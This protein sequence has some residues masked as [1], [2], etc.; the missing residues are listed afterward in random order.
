MGLGENI[1]GKVKE[2]LPV[3][4]LALQDQVKMYKLKN[5]ATKGGKKCG[6][7]MSVEKAS[8]SL[9]RMKETTLFPK[10]YFS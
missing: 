9:A 7:G 6:V 8:E 2:M 10:R 5:S 3:H 1:I 4:C